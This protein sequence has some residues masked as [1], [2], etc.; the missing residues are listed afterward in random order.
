MTTANTKSGRN[1]RMA[2]IIGGIV[3]LLLIVVGSGLIVGLLAGLVTF[4]VAAMLLP[5]AETEVVAAPGPASVSEPAPVETETTPEVTASVAAEPIKAEPAPAMSG[6]VKASKVL[7]GQQ[8]LAAR[9]GTWRFENKPS[10]A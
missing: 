5:Q 2:A 10:T 3:A 8:E 4:G 6:L 7:P 9:K 1:W